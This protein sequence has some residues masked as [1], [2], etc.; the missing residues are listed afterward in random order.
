MDGYDFSH[1]ILALG[2]YVFLTGL[3]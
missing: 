2:S 1:H 3:Q